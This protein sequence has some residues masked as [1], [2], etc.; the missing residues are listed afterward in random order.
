MITKSWWYILIKLELSVSEKTW[1]LFDCLLFSASPCIFHSSQLYHLIFYY[2]ICIVTE[3]IGTKK[4]P[5][6]KNSCHVFASFFLCFPQSLPCCMLTSLFTIT[7]SVLICVSVSS[8]LEILSARC[9][10][11]SGKF[12]FVRMSDKVPHP[13]WSS[14]FYFFFFFFKVN[15]FFWMCNSNGQVRSVENFV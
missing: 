2:T 3:S 15:G 12:I 10:D 13:S 4:L 8:D 6:T 9:G 14:F 7:Q 1:A 11:S 5:L